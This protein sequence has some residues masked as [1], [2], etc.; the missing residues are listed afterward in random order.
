MPTD[1]SSTTNSTMQ[2]ILWVTRLSLGPPEPLPWGAERMSGIFLQTL[3]L[4]TL[5]SLMKMKNHSLL[6]LS[7]CIGIWITITR[8]TLG[9]VLIMNEDYDDQ[10][11]QNESYLYYWRTL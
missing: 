5:L 4:R 10:E 8:T 6:S 11:N 1:P 9:M 3:G 7:H 2:G